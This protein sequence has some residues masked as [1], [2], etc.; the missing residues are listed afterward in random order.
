MPRKTVF[1]TALIAALIPASA[2]HA[3]TLNPANSIADQ[4]VTNNTA[5][6]PIYDLQD[7]PY[8]WG[9]AFQTSDAAGKAIFKFQNT[10]DSTS[11]ISVSLG[12]VL[13][14]LGGRFQGGVTVKWKNGGSAFI[15]G[16]ELGT[17]SISKLLEIGEVGVLKVIFGD[18]LQR[19]KS[20]PG[21]QLQVSDTSE[22]IDLNP[23]PIP[24]A[25]PLLA[26]ALLGL[27]WFGRAR[28]LKPAQ[29]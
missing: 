13:Q 28:K 29:V 1:A 12:T 4:I 11:Q 3:L 17:F 25:F 19:R 14:G 18:P 8:F 6:G 20:A 26:G 23:V 21:I 7:G 27:G 22:D 16:G 9:A 5:N 10:S 15:G 2:V 24:A